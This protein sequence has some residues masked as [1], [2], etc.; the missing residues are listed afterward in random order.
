VSVNA[1]FICP[2]KLG[3]SFLKRL[4]RASSGKKKGTEALSQGLKFTT[5]Q[6]KGTEGAKTGNQGGSGGARGRIED[7]G[8]KRT[9]LIKRAWRNQE[10][11]REY[12]KKGIRSSL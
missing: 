10:K 6:K 3:G 8:A 1:R 2:N 7:G 4:R 12:G 9:V 5:S 11:G